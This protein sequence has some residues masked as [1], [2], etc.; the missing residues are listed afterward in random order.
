MPRPRLE[1]AELLVL[2]QIELAKQFGDETIRAAVIGKQIV[3]D[4][5]AAGPPQCLVTVHAQEIAG[6]LQLAPVP[7]F[8]CG[9]EVTVGAG[10]HQIDRV[11]V[12]A[13]AQEY[14]KVGHPIR[15]SE[16]EHVDIELRDLLHVLAMKG[17][18]T[19]R[20]RHDAFGWKFLVEE[21]GALE[22]LDR[23]AFRVL[24]DEHVGD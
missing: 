23:R 16:A 9:V 10:A 18:V 22:H 1:V 20:V 2:H 6:L 5:V 21:F 15:L 8:E 17:D 11:M 3:A 4:A 12:G 24:K 13:A 7:H 19:E 14:E